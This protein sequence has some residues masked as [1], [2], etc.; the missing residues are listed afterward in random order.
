MAAH[1][2]QCDSVDRRLLLEKDV[3]ISQILTAKQPA[4]LI[5]KHTG[6]NYIRQPGEFAVVL[7]HGP[8][9]Y[10]ELLRLLRLLEEA[11]EHH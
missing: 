11:N 1:G 4:E 6:V 10:T 8:Y 3:N 5:E 2:G 7:P 9:T